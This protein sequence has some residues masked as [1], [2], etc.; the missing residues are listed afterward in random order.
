MRSIKNKKLIDHK[1]T[2]H[3]L[4]ELFDYHDD[5]YLIWKI[6]AAN[7]VKPSRIAG[8][9]N[10]AGYRRITI[11]G[12][13]FK[14]HRLIYLWHHGTLPKMLDHIDGIRQNNRINNLRG[15]THEQNMANR[16]FTPSRRSQ[17]RNVRRLPNGMYRVSFSRKRCDFKQ[18]FDYELLAHSAA[19]L[20]RNLVDGEFANHGNSQ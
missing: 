6:K 7:N 9:L 13:D 1:I 15:C 19:T 14:A 11:D 2:Q 16:C 12:H 10:D 5:G 17:Y 20:I 3:K 4:K 18:D 8:S